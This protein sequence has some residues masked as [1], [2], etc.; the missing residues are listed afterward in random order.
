MNIY[1]IIKAW[2]E[3]KAEHPELTGNH[4]DF[5]FYCIDLN[6]RLAWKEEFGLPAIETAEYLGISYNTFRKLFKE[7]TQE[8]K[9]IRLVKASKNQYTANIISLDLLYQN[10]LKQ[11]KGT[12]KSFVQKQE[13]QYQDSYKVLYQNLLKQMK[14]T[15]KANEKHLKS[16]CDINIHKD[17]Y[18]LLHKYIILL[19]TSSDKS[20]DDLVSE[21]D[22]NNSSLK[23]SSLSE[24]EEEKKRTPQI[25]ASTPL[26]EKVRKNIIKICEAVWQ[27]SPDEESLQKIIDY[28]Q[29][30]GGAGYTEGF[31][32]FWFG[33]LNKKGKG[34][35]FKSFQK[36]N[37]QD[38]MDAI[39]NLPD[40]NARNSDKEIQYIPHPS[41]WLNQ[42]R[43][44][45]EQ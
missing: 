44:E 16:I 40:W 7:F 38:R 33:Y 17:I 14:S 15:E 42:R 13:Q 11:T 12:Y 22:S 28:M 8:Y 43:W 27:E 45:D 30:D 6:N 10:L 2:Y 41:T 1:A 39:K 36:L 32:V 9:L 31:A 4:T 18:T 34:S 35:A 26:K 21:K 24:S 37:K 5:L 3:Y 25:S 23:K 19:N 29:V 20:S